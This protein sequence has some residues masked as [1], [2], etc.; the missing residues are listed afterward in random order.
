[1]TYTA[2]S[3]TALAHALLAA[4]GMDSHRAATTARCIITADVWGIHS[5]GLLRLPYYLRWMADGGYP[6]AAQLRTVRDTGPVVSYSGGGGMGHWQ[7]WEAAEL[8]S[9]RCSQYGIATVSVADSGH[10]GALGLYT[11]P[12]AQAKQLT[13]AFSNGP[14][15]MAPWGTATKLL[16]TSPLAAGVPTTPGPIVVDM[17]TS[18]VARGKIATHAQS[19]TP[20]PQGWALDADGNPTVDPQ[21]GLQGLLSPLGGAKGSAL[22]LLVESLTGGL[23]GPNLSADVPDMFADAAASS[24]Q[25]IGHLLVSM[26][27][28]VFDGGTGAAARRLDRLAESV[29]AAGG[30]LPGQ[31]RTIPEDIAPDTVLNL[32]ETTARE[33]AAWAA[34]LGVPIP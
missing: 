34:T 25:R 19:G 6:P 15:V 14:A 31:N 21:A 33:L 24:P 3:A 1:M 5:H 7:L 26:D 10:C 23:A 9:K 8:A 13:M 28:A 29:R 30:R 22:A 27:P 16:S 18:A 20:L 4:S 12:G 2:G 17:A 11:L 32:P